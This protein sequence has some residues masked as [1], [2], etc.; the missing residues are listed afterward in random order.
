ME[1]PPFRS[2][3]QAVLDIAAQRPGGVVHESCGTKR[4]ISGWTERHG[5]L[6]RPAQHCSQR[7]V[8]SGC[9]G[10]GAAA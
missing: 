3:V 10:P 5:E 7:G 8:F 9:P 4:V 1:R 2:R 6:V